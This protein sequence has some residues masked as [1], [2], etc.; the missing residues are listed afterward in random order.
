VIGRP[1]LQRVRHT[2]LLFLLPPHRHALQIV[3]SRPGDSCVTCSDPKR[4]PAPLARP[5][6]GL[7]GRHGAGNGAAVALAR[8]PCGSRPLRWHSPGDRDPRARTRTRTHFRPPRFSQKSWSPPCRFPA[9]GMMKM[10]LN[11]GCN[12]KDGGGCRVGGRRTLE[13]LSVSWSLARMSTRTRNCCPGVRGARGAECSA[14]RHPLAAALHKE[15]ASWTL[16]ILR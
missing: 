9:P 3:D 6:A 2:P 15:A 16:S 13:P 8:L 5:V 10:G 1:V 4:E 12:N 14:P 7:S 11:R